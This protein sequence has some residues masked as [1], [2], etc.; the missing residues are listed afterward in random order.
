MVTP[1][2]FYQLTWYRPVLINVSYYQIAF[3]TNK[4]LLFMTT[5][6][7]T[8]MLA[9]SVIGSCFLRKHFDRLADNGKVMISL[10]NASLKLAYKFVVNP[11]SYIAV[12]GY[13]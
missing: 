6:F 13:I 5:G 1:S 7:R 11:V 8:K 12:L 4:C 3:H 10:I 2:P 9:S